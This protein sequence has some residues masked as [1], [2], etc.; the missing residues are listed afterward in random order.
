VLIGHPQS[1]SEPRDMRAGLV[2]VFRPD[3]FVS[4]ERWTAG[5]NKL[6]SKCYCLFL[7]GAK[8]LRTLH[9]P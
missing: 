6:S 5:P 3:A 8:A 2:E 7:S 9:I 1:G 4:P